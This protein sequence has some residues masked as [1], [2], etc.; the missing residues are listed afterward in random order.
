M[1]FLVIEKKCHI[2]AACNTLIH[3]QFYKMVKVLQ[4]NR[5]FS[6]IAPKKE[7]SLR[8]NAVTPVHRKEKSSLHIQKTS[9]ARKK[10]ELPSKQYLPLLF[11]RKLSL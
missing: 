5:H 8:I 11:T 1:H 4:I 10:G 3:N 7:C 9:L 6:I 2:L